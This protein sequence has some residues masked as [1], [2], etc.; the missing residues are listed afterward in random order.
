M[1]P[2]TGGAKKAKVINEVMNKRPS[3]AQESSSKGSGAE[4]VNHQ[5]E[6]PENRGILWG[7]SKEECQNMKDIDIYAPD[8]DINLLFGDLHGAALL[9]KIYQV[10]GDGVF[11]VSWFVVG[12]NGKSESASLPASSGLHRA[13]GLQRTRVG[14]RYGLNLHAVN[15]NFTISYQITIYTRHTLQSVYLCFH[16]VS[17]L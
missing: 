10:Y 2:K 8:V 6:M 15:N 3:Q 12:P 7:K 17:E 1:A 5:E 9:D 4:P 13:A 11:D 16:Q 14:H